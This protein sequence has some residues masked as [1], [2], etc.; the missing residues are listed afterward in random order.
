MDI[1]VFNSQCEGYN[2]LP[3]TIDVHLKQRSFNSSL[4]IFCHG[5]KGFKDWGS[6]NFIANEFAKSGFAFLK[7]NF[8]HN[9]TTPEKLTEF[10]D[11]EAFS[12]NNFSIELFDLDCV[13]NWVQESFANVVGL[14]YNSIILMGHSRGGGIS[15]L[16]A[17]TDKRISKL[18]TWSA[19]SDFEKRL[20]AYQI[21]KWKEDQI[22][23]IANS[24]TNQ[25]L[26]LHYQFYE[27]FVKNKEKL[28]I[29]ESARSIQIPWLIVHAKDDEVVLPIEAML[30][31]K[32]NLKTQLKWINGGGHTFGAKHPFDN[33]ANSEVLL[34]A[35]SESINFTEINQA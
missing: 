18:I 9:G 7:F 17:A 30:L 11:L 12:Q 29:L 21:D 35:I 1:Q 14:P 24:R 10:G 2:K 27:D 4:V 6:F 22:I 20:S 28:N 19:V 25:Q 34:D 31:E 26:P 33:D 8:S 3:I 32:S 16:K 13:L 5:F 23:Y 15:I